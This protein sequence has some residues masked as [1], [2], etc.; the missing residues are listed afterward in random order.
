MRWQA[1]CH[2]QG[3]LHHNVSLTGSVPLRYTYIIKMREGRRYIELD[4][5]Y[6]NA[7]EKFLG[8]STP[9]GNISFGIKV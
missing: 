6:Q 7:R 5:T 4:A 2:Q 8:H 9:I 3:N 1:S